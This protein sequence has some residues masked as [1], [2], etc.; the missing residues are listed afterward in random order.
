[1]LDLIGSIFSANELL[2][3]DKLKQK[4]KVRMEED[5]SLLNILQDHIKPLKPGEQVSYS[6]QTNKMAEAI[7]GVEPLIQD[8]LET[9]LTGNVP[10]GYQYRS[11]KITVLEQN[12]LNIYG[13]SKATFLKTALFNIILQLAQNTH[14]FDFNN[15]K[16]SWANHSPTYHITPLPQ[17]MGYDE[18]LKL[19][20]RFSHFPYFL[21]GDQKWAQG[22]FC[23]AHSGYAFGGDRD[24]PHFVKG[25]LYGPEDCS[26]WIE[27]LTGSPYSFSTQDQLYGYRHYLAESGAYIP[28]EWKGSPVGS[29][30]ARYKPVAILNPARGI[31]EGQIHTFRIFS[32]TDPSMQT[33]PGLRGHTTLVLGPKNNGDILTLSYARN[34]PEYEGFGIKTFPY[35]TPFPKKTMF[36]NVD[37]T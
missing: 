13:S 18:F 31:K 17:K 9:L 14:S 1:M 10:V 11:D 24:N 35:Q 37:P 8:Y 4:I 21:K 29:N 26:S 12:D 22:Y 34:M 5:L 36:F 25:K 15:M 30:T 32:D 27:K 28:A 23:F 3:E 33:T 2:D 19:D 6:L 16:L 20:E 7:R